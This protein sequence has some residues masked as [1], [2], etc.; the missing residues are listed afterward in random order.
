[1]EIYARFYYQL[2]G[3]KNIGLRFFIVYGPRGRPYMTPYK[4]F[5]C[6]KKK[7]KKNL[8]NLEMVHLQETIHT[9]MILLK[10]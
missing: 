5:K 3:I 4:F 8:K 1:M 9:L 7:M 10:E 2:Y 6:Y